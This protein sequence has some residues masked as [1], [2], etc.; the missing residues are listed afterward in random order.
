[1]N[2]DPFT[3]TLEEARAQPD[4]HA[5][6]D[7]AVLRWCVAQQIT[8]DRERM[9]KYPIDGIATCVRHGLIAPDWL[10]F[11]FIR[12]YDKVLR[13]EVSTWD[14]AFGPAIA[15]GKHISTLRLMRLH[16][17]QLALLFMDDEFHGRKALPRTLAGRH[18]AA[19][20][21]GITEPQV[22]S[23]LGTTRKNIR[24]HKPYSRKSSNHVNA[25]NPFGL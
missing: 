7:G 20:I 15:P 25:N 16:G 4:A 8:Q 23:M 6:P 11:P 19:R 18:E 1:M 5:T 9:E 13:Y 10:A 12:Q 21:L 24:G 3:A 17:F 14:K 2:F 22:R